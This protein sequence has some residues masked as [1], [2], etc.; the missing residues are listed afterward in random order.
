MYVERGTLG[1]RNEKMPVRQ[2]ELDIHTECRRGEKSHSR[3]K[4]NKNGLSY[5]S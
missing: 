1:G 4:F 3:M 5:K 2:S